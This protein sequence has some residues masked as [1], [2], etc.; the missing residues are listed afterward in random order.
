MMGPPVK[1]LYIL[2]AAR[3]GSTLLGGL[4]EQVDGVSSQGELV[5]FWERAV[6]REHSC[7]CG[8]S[9]GSCARWS[10]VTAEWH[11]LRGSAQRMVALARRVRRRRH[12]PF[13]L[14]L[15][16]TRQYRQDLA[17]YR[18]Q[19]STFYR[20]IREET[21]ARLLVDESK[22]P[23]YALA[24][25][26]IEHIDLHVLH[27]VRDSRATAYSWSRPKRLADLDREDARLRR[28]PTRRSAWVWLTDHLGSL[29][30]RLNS[31]SYTRLRYEDFVAAPEATL[32]AA[33]ADLGLDLDLRGVT[34]ASRPRK[35]MHTIAGNP[36][37][38]GPDWLSIT[39]DEEWRTAIR[40]RD[41][42]LVT[43]I[44]WP[45]LLWFG[46]PLRGDRRG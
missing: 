42:R 23:Y 14:G 45:L 6:L 27:L 3:S 43:A 12:V 7:S 28:W 46:Y 34:T 17:E 25:Q 2:G 33:V 16:A 19:L 24:L 10:G 44:T 31:R 9:I 1:V 20:R 11:D 38:F 41:F 32:A 22:H 4:L 26:G 29:I 40:P 13:L 36:G 18:A 5:W 39:P 8:Q 37:R 35:A 21:G 15:R 30:V